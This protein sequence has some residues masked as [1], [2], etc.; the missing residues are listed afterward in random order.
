M[1][2]FNGPYIAFRTIPSM[3]NF[4]HLHS[5]HTANSLEKKSMHF[6]R[7]N[8]SNCLTCCDGDYTLHSLWIITIYIKESINTHNGSFP[9]KIILSEHLIFIYLN[10]AK[11]CIVCLLGT[12][13]AGELVGPLIP[14]HRSNGV[15]ND[16][17][18]LKLR[19]RAWKILY[20]L[21]IYCATISY[22]HIDCVSYLSDR[23]FTSSLCSSYSLF[24][25]TS[26]TAVFCVA[27]PMALNSNNKANTNEYESACKSHRNA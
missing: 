11:L 8:L 5:L 26:V 17:S 20:P 10:T 21:A 4:T 15:L 22:T 3:Y 7:P 12:K 16:M 19:A 1:N 13:M 23:L 6:F 14:P 18:H 27:H 25:L 2:S 9:L 24:R